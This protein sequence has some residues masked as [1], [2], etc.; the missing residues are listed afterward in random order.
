MFIRKIN[1]C[2]EKERKQD[3][4][5]EEVKLQWIASKPWPTRLEALEQTELKWLIF[6]SFSISYPSVI[7]CGLP[8]KGKELK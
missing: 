3:W 8:W 6:I 1:T 2:E 5:W 4:G 7:L